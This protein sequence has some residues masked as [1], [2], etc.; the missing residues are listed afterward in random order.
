[1]NV[2]AQIHRCWTVDEKKIV[3]STKNTGNTPKNATKENIIFPILEMIIQLWKKFQRVL[4]N[5]FYK[6]VTEDKN[7]N[8]QMYCSIERNLKVGEVCIFLFAGFWVITLILIKSLNIL[9]QTLGVGL[10]LKIFLSKLWIHKMTK[11]LIIV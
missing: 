7:L 1:M 8:L 4:L 11:L 10:E 5:R 6:I 3:L 2:E 9:S